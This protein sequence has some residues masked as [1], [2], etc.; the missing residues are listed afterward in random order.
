MSLS[1]ARAF[2]RQQIALVDPKLIEWRDSFNDENIPQTKIDQ[3][4]H[5]EFGDLA[6]VKDENSIMDSWIVTVHIWKRGFNNPIDAFDSIIDTG[7]CIRLKIIDSRATLTDN[8]HSVESNSIFSE[9]IDDSNDNTI[10]ISLE[11]N[12]KLIF[13]TS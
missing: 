11:F 13:T 6:S 12:I 4:Y 9:P 1:Q 8:I 3:Y 2:I 10:K 5:I 7:N